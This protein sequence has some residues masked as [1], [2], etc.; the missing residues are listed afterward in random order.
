MFKIQIELWN[1]FS[2][3]NSKSRSKDVKSAKEFSS[4]G[5]RTTYSSRREYKRTVRIIKLRVFK[6]NGGT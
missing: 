5:K 6:R 2:R 1:D 4:V 3:R